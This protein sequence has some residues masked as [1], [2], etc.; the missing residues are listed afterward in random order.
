MRIL[1]LYVAV[2]AFGSSLMPTVLAAN[3]IASY[4]ESVAVLQRDGVIDSGAIQHLRLS[5]GINRAEA[6]K[7]ILKAQPK[8]SSSLSTVSAS[9]PPLSL[10]S[11]VDQRSWYAPYV[12]VGF[13][14]RL[15]KGYPDGS[16][17]PEYAVTVEEA[18][19][20]ITRSFGENTESVPFRTSRDLMNEEGQWYTGAL[21]LLIARN[22]ILPG[23]ELSPGMALTRGDFFDILQRMRRAHGIDAPSPTVTVQPSQQSYIGETSSASQA[24]VQVVNDAAA[25]QYASTK[26]FAL[27]IP[28][29][30]I[31]DLTVTHPEDAFTQKGVLSILKDGVGHLFAYPGEGSKV[32]I[33]GHSSGY[34]WDVSKYTKIFR[35]INKIEIGSRLYITYQGKVFVYQVMEK[36]IVPAKDRSL[37][38]P[39][40]SGES[41][42]LYTCWPPDSISQRY[43]VRAVPIEVI[44]LR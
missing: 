30:G 3:T 29:I 33:Y 28:S 18:A 9:M 16:L 43:T 17:R 13:R 34:P 37:F 25:L 36:K 24:N 15:I 23:S 41:L 10:F 11:D 19:A 40:D 1:S 38:E 42:L 22:A 12:E 26:P 7:V 39:D 32:M 14:S 4:Q 35:T 20:M 8:F 31:T 44:A 21:S 5:Q 2:S 27:S 6:L